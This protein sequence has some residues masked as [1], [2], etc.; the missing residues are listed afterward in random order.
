MRASIILAALILGLAPLALVAVDGG[1]LGGLFQATETHV[2]TL[3][4]S[5]MT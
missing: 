1:S 4:I 5:G 2:V 3:S